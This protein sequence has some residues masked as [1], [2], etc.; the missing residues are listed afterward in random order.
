MSTNAK[1]CAICGRIKGHCSR[2]HYVHDR[3]WIELLK[4]NS[5]PARK[6]AKQVLGNDH[7][8]RNSRDI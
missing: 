2:C 7:T 4:S 1:Y 5:G 8:T 3:S 6:A